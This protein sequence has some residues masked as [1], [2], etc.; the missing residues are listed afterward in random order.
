M[1]IL[2]TDLQA[3]HAYAGKAFLIARKRRG[4]LAN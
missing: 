3:I 4:V 2:S 1:Q